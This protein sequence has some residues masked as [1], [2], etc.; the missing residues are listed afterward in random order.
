MKR[1]LVTGSLG[2]LGSV[3]VNYLSENGFNVVGY[4]VGFFSRALLYTPAPVETIFRDARTIIEKDLEGIDAVVHLAGIS[5]DPVGNLDAAL[6]YD[7]TRVYSLY[8][9]KMCKKMGVRFIFSSSCSVYGLGGHELLTESSTTHPQTFYSLNK[10][11][12][13]GDL[14]SISDRD[15]S[16]IALRFATVFGPSPRIRFDVVINMLAGMAVSSGLVVLNS[17]GLS[18]R[19]NLHILDACQ[20]ILRAIEL[21]YR[22]GE[23]LIL[24]VGADTDNMQVLDIAKIIQK[25]NPSCELKF[26]SDNPQLDKE[27]LINDRKVKDGDDTRTYKVSFAKIRTVMPDFECQWNVERGVIEMVELFKVLPLTSALFKSR[28]FYRL[29]QLEYLHSGGYV[30]DELFW[31]KPQES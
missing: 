1:I 25:V 20:A 2:Y 15:F 29:Q 16:P 8:I 17:D 31:L 10:L 27:G 19:P 7:P 9:A 24:N 30:S 3:L 13:E 6:V 21:E 23:L 12:I 4:D 28:G 14:Q 22:A 18:W 11:Q 26:L 5:N